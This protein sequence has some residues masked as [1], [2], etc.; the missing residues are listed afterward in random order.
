MTL[1]GR[2]FLLDDD[3]LI[4]SMLARSLKKEGYD[5]QSETSTEDIMS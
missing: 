1:K 3:E 5:V 4:C 2:I